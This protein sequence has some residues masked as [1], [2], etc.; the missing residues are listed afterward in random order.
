MAVKI[1]T[2]SKA[3]KMVYVPN[4][5]PYMDRFVFPE[6][7]PP[8]NVSPGVSILVRNGR[9]AKTIAG[10]GSWHNKHILSLMAM[11]CVA[12]DA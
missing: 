5:I 4:M 10:H 2:K 6:V 1:F 7:H 12:H 8:L 3:N 11:A 9:R